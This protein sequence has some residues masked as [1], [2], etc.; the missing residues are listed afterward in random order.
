MHY[1]RVSLPGTFSIKLAFVS[2][3]VKAL[4]DFHVRKGINSIAISLASTNLGHHSVVQTLKF[5]STS[6]SLSEFLDKEFFIVADS[7]GIDTE[8]EIKQ[9]PD[10]KE[11][12]VFY[13][14]RA[15]Q[16]ARE[17]KLKTRASY[18]LNKN[19]EGGG[20][21]TYDEILSNLKEVWAAKAQEKMSQP[22]LIFK[23]DS[24][25]NKRPFLMSI[26]H[27]EP[28]DRYKLSSY[29]FNTPVPVFD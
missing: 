6:K 7:L 19:Q 20:D 15:A 9:V 10:F 14:C 28:D 5:I 1:F 25:T 16:Y 11:M 26:R 3:F 12:A 13:Q 17:S 4:H 27:R 18:V 24:N 22:G 23:V 8:I 21:K 2:K 29:G